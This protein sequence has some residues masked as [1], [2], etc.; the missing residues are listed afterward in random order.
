MF[1]T[2]RTISYN[3]DRSSVLAGAGIFLFATDV[4]ERNL[5]VT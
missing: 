5:L 3:L 2:F 4:F 1:S